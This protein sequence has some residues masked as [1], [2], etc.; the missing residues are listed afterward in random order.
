MR[1]F[2]AYEF[3]GYFSLCDQKLLRLLD[4][5]REQWGRPIRIS[6]ADGAIARFDESKSRHNVHEWGMVKAIDIHPDGIETAD[7]AR[8]FFALCKLVGFKGIGFYPNWNTVGFHV[9]VRDTEDV[10]T[11]G[12]YYELGSQKYYSIEQAFEDFEK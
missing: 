7:D 1:H 10:A 11:W 4:E 6:Q 2:E 9:D 12:A 8:E 5:T 3:R